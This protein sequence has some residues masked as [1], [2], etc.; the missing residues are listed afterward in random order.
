[1]QMFNVGDKVEFAFCEAMTASATSPW[2]IRPLTAVGKKLGGGADTPALC[3]RKVSWDLQGDVK[4]TMDSYR[5]ATSAGPSYVCNAC[6]EV[7]HAS[8][9]RR[10]IGAEHV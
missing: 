1:M 10:E 5:K 2:H 7:Y 3:G 8:E 4:P 9:I 6:A